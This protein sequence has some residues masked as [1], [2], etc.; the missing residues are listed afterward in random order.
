MFEFL[1]NDVPLEKKTTNICIQNIYKNRS[2]T[3]DLRRKMF[4]P[5]C[6]KTRFLIMCIQRV[7]IF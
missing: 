1:S 7:E 6:P 3:N 2:H 5:T 4:G